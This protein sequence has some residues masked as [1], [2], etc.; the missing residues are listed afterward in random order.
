MDE[1]SARVVA[2]V[3][4][5]K[6]LLGR[7]YTYVYTLAKMSPEDVLEVHRALRESLPKQS[8]VRTSDPALSDIMSDEVARE[9]DRF[10]Q[11]VEKQIAAA[12]PQ[13]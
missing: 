7:L 10:L 11:G 1:E 2:T 8:L 5:M 3:A 9:M 12:K 6:L 13:S 4:A